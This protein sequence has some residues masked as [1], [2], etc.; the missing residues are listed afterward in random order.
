LKVVLVSHQVDVPPGVSETTWIKL[1]GTSSLPTLR[2]KCRMLKIGKCIRSGCHVV[3]SPKLQVDWISAGVVYIWKSTQVTNNHVREF[4]SML[5]PSRMLRSNL[6][7]L[8]WLVMLV[9]NPIALSLSSRLGSSQVVEAWGYTKLCPSPW[10][11]CAPK[12]ETK[13]GQTSLGFPIVFVGNQGGF[14]CLIIGWHKLSSSNMWETCRLGFLMVYFRANCRIESG[15][16]L[17][18]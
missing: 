6:V 8:V 17:V 4:R 18:H 3:T 2:V 15:A 9:W 10:K 14:S 12:K 7:T 11:V 13:V 1:H 16:K 5:L